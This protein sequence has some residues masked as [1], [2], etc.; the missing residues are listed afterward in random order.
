MTMGIETWLAVIGG[1]FALVGLVAGSL[2]VVRSS[3]TRT[4]LEILR[5]SVDDYEKRTDQLIEE[6]DESRQREA[7]VQVRLDASQREVQVLRDI[8]TSKQ[9]IQD[10]RALIELNHKELHG[11]VTLLLKAI[12]EGAR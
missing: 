3:Y 5:A 1:I 11:G 10:L 9:E 4:Q 12:D 2:A 6:R 7:A 8:V